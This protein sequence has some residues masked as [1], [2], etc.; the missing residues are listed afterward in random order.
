[1]PL[2][3]GSQPNI[4][5]IRNVNCPLQLDLFLTNQNV[6]LPYSHSMPFAQQKLVA[7]SVRSASSL[8]ESNMMDNISFF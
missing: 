2:G 4:T 7:L 8:E 1:M 3:C 6:F 5:N